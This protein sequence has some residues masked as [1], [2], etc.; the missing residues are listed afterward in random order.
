MKKKLVALL[1]VL[2]MVFALLPTTALAAQASYSYPS[3]GKANRVQISSQDAEMGLIEPGANYGD[4]NGNDT[5]KF[6]AV[7]NPGY[8]FDGWSVTGE[9]FVNSISKNTATLSINYKKNNGTGDPGNNVFKAVAKFKAVGFTVTYDKNGATD[10]S[11]P[12]DNTKYK[13]GDQVTVA[14]NTGGL[15]KTGYVFGGWVYNGTTYSAG[16]SFQMGSSNV[17]LTA[18]WI[19]QYNVT[20][21]VGAHGKWTD[22]NGIADKTIG[23]DPGT[24]PVAPGITADPGYEHTGW[25]PVLEAAAGPKTYTATY[26]PL[27]YNITY[28]L[29]GGTVNGNPETYTIET[30]KFTLKNPTKPGFE[31]LGW[32]SPDFSGT[33]KT[34]TIDKGTTGN[35][36]YTAEWREIK[37][38]VKFDSNHG[39]PNYADQSVPENGKA[40]NPGSPQRTGYAF[41]GWWYKSGHQYGHDV[42]SRWNFDTD[43]VTKDITLYANWIQTHT[44]TFNPDNGESVPD[45]TVKNGDKVIQPTDPVKPGYEFKGWWYKSCGHD[46]QW[47]FDTKVYSDVALKAKWKAIDYTVTYNSNNATSGSVPTDSNVYHI[48]DTVTVKENSGNLQRTGFTFE[49]WN[50]AANGSGISYPSSGTFAMGDSNVILYAEWE[51]IDRTVTYN[52]NGATSGTVPV[53]NTV[54]HYTDIAKVAGNTGNLA[55]AGHTFAGWNT[56]ADGS[57]TP[58]ASDADL[59]I[60]EADVVLYA[61]WKINSYEVKFFQQDGTTQIG[62][63]QKIDWNKAA[64]LETAPAIAGYAFDKWVLTGDNPDEADSLM[65]VKENLKAVASYIKNGYTVT[66]L[67]YSGKVIGTCGVL[68]GEDATAPTVPAR[69][70]YTFT[71]WDKPFTN[72]T[73]NLTVTAQYAINTYTVKFVDH[74]GNVLSTQTV[75]WN[76]AAT[77]PAN[78]TRTG[79]K[80]IGWDKAFANVTS[81]LTVTA[82]Y[83]INTY[84]VKFVDH[85]GKVLS[86]QTV[87]WNTAAIAPAN[88]TRTGYKFTSWDKAFTNVT[89]DLTITAQY[90]K[91]AD[92]VSGDDENIPKTYDDGTEVTLQDESVPVG[93]IFGIAWWWIAVAAVILGAF[94]WL[95]IFLVR[96]NRK[97][98]EIV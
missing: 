74:G 21:K 77:A 47:D 4:F 44:V 40:T 23:V 42:Y 33:K 55:L 98:D 37:Y 14:G 86:T 71:G 45:Q 20:F 46:Y 91:N 54:Y 25:N 82:R 83:A 16:E 27:T 85:D 79:H 48:N 32:S 62:I 22:N 76:T 75:N 28:T 3:N 88:P 36:S 68:H 80:F 57:G 67:D 92:A 26:K 93:Q 18:K 7:P 60:G 81:D 43:T 38:T 59:S 51:A 24:T 95:V 96:R 9:S 41:D 72:V 29:N 39:T 63:T 12:I 89:S 11:V 64:D 50:T 65:N 70:G 10:G 49:G 97:T 13:T 5:W 34:V 61:Q 66:F 84:T 31:F 52:A 53:D 87:N 8:E 15:V 58:Y 78:P 1:V 30:P 2:L 73:G 94:A 19:Q 90:K 69:D 6:T 56:E 35:K 17:K